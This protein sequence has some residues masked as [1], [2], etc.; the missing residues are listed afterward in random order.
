MNKNAISVRFTSCFPR[1]TLLILA[2]VETP[3][4]IDEPV[5]ELTI[6]IPGRSLTTFVFMIDN[7]GTAVETTKE[8]SKGPQGR[9]YD[10]QGRTL[11]A[12][13]GLY[14]E[15]GSDGS[16]RKVYRP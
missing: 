7:E 13:G 10:L 15:Q 8:D 16:V 1:T 14:I 12:P 6:N 2:G 5:Q 3:I 9:Y 4:A 11:T